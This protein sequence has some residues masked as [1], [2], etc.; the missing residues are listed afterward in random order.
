MTLAFRQIKRIDSGCVTYL[1][2]SQET[3]E[4]AI[5]DPLL[6]TEYV[7]EEA[8]KAG[9]A[10]ITH[11][12]DTHTHA[13]HISGARSLARQFGL[14]GVHMHEKSGSKFKTIPVKDGQAIKLGN[15]EL[16]FIY[17]PGHTYDHVCVLVDGSKLLTGDTMFIGDVGRIDLGGDARDKSDRLYDSLR[18]LLELADSVEVYPTHVGAAHHLGNAKTSSTIGYERTG[19]GALKALSDREAFFKYMT[20]DWPPKPP[21]YQNIIRLNKGEVSVP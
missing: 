21:D 17:T 7:V 19:N 4:C 14:A 13:D 16:R 6:D 10:K 5:I 11:V 15:H 12:I 2:G 3:G 9:F 20:E 1:V 8:K 18:R